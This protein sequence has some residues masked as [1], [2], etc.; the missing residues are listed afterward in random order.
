[1]SFQTF[2]NNNESYQTDDTAENENALN[3]ST[4]N[5]TITQT[6]TTTT[7]P[8]TTAQTVTRTTLP[9]TITPTT[10]IRTTTPTTTTPTTRTTLPPTTTITTAARTDTTL[11]PSTSTTGKGGPFKSILTRPQLEELVEQKA[12]EKLNIL[13]QQQEQIQQQHQ[14]QLAREQQDNSPHNS[15]MANDTDDRLAQDLRQLRLEESIS[16]IST[17]PEPR[18]FSHPPPVISCIPASYLPAAE[19]V[20]T[21]HTNEVKQQFKTAQNLQ[22]LA[23]FMQYSLDAQHLPQEAQDIANQLL[24]EVRLTR[25]EALSKQEGLKKAHK[26]VNYY[27]T[28][29]EKPQTTHT[30]L[31]HA[32][33]I[34]NLREIIMVTGYFDPQDPTADFKHTWQKLL[35]YG[36][37]LYF[38]ETHYMQA[39]SAILKKEAYEIFNDFKAAGRD[40]NAILDYFSKVYTKKRSL[41]ADRQAVD[42]FTRKKNESILICMDRCI[43]DIDK[44]RHLYPDSSWPDMRQQ[45]R[46]NI[47]MQ[48]IKEETKRYIQMEEDEI[49]ET[50]GMPYDFDKLIKLADRYERHHNAIPPTDVTTVFKVASGG[51]EPKFKPKDQGSDPAQ[52]KKENYQDQIR[53]LKSQIDDLKSNNTQL[54]YKNQA[55]PEQARESRRRDRF[56]SSQRNRDISR[57]RTRDLSSESKPMEIEDL[58][59]K[60]PTPVPSIKPSYTPPQSPT[61]QNRNPYPPRAFEQYQGA[62][63][64]PPSPQPQQ[65]Q[66]QRPNTPPYISNTQQQNNTPYTQ[67]QQQYIPNRS[68]SQPN[69]QPYQQPYEQRSF[70]PTQQRQ[71]YI[72]TSQQQPYRSSSPSQQQYTSQQQQPYRSTSPFRQS[73]TSQQ[74]QPFRPR[75]PYQSPQRQQTQYTPYTNN[76]NSRELMPFNSNNQ[77]RTRYGSLS[78]TG[79]NNSPFQYRSNSPQRFQQQPF[80]NYNSSYNSQQQQ[81]RQPFQSYNNNE[82]WQQRQPYRD[83]S[84]SYDRNN[85]NNRPNNDYRN[86]SNSDNREL[87]THGNKAVYITINGQDYIAKPQ[88][89]N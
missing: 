14:A 67:Q 47:L 15:T 7:P 72:P 39:L 54:L 48:V 69:R 66:P 11:T 22:K 61:P 16:P 42:K 32:P 49:T 4:H 89:E 46:R 70:S 31:T 87:V 85:S 64:R 43:L 71:P 9:P 28:P 60:L 77:N 35:D 3:T 81:Q 83:R 29:I 86:R 18:I 75:S 27:E 63:Q 55:R 17:P 79:R 84:P 8:T 24:E 5:T 10:V 34:F 37:P 6:P 68:Q 41:L 51:F 73:Y 1:M 38:R 80:Q 53:D 45:M 59:I 58:G 62:Y 74:Q 21:M 44:L 56:D 23:Q 76:S 25:Q 36:T 50:T 13:L 12:N 30:S 19:Q 26:V 65:R 88:S 57:N 52:T 78:P 2:R 33:I 82:S 40:L 20:L